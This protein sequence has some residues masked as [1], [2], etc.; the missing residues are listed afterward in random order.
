MEARIKFCDINM[1]GGVGAIIAPCVFRGQDAPHYRPGFYTLLA[2]VGVA[3]INTA[4]LICK[5][6]RANRRADRGDGF[7]GGLESFRYVL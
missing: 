3:C 7:G 2:A 4:L 5:L 1:A 6:W